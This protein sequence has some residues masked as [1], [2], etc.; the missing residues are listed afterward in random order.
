MFSLGR[1]AGAPRSDW[2]KFRRSFGA[3]AGTAQNV[4]PQRQGDD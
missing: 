2:G 1:S 4:M 3:S